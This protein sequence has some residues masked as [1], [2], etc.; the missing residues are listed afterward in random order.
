MLRILSILLI[1]FSFTALQACKDKTETPE[2]AATKVEEKEFQ[3][4]SAHFDALQI[5]EWIKRTA[6]RAGEEDKKKAEA[7]AG[8]F[9]SEEIIAG[10]S[11]RPIPDYWHDVPADK[12]SKTIAIMNTSLS[13]A[14]I[15]AG[16]AENLEVLNSTLYLENEKGVIIAASSPDRGTEL[17][18]EPQ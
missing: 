11:V 12:R 15:E 10:V 4:P 7:A 18:E 17:F 6:A 5:K 2:K 3:P 14:R 16:L 8:R 1:C 13:K 9:T